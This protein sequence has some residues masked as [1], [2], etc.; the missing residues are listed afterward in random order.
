MSDSVVRPSSDEEW[1]AL[2][3]Q[4]HN[5]PKARLGPF[6]YTRLHARLAAD[7]AAKSPLFPAWLRRP[8]YVALLGAL[9][10]TL[11]GDGSALRPAAEINHCATCPIIR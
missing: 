6:F 9:V 4:L 8:A 2:M 11:S 5:Q 3:Y 10:I 1:E 7:A